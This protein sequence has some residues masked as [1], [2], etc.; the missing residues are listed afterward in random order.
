LRNALASNGRRLRPALALAGV[1]ALAGW[2]A[3]PG[4]APAPAAAPCTA[5]DR[6]L[7]AGTRADALAGAFRLTLV[8]TRGP[9]AD[10]S[11][12]GDLRLQP[13]GGRPVPLPASEGVRYALFGA[14]EVEIAGVGA[15]SRGAV[16]IDDAARPG[17]LAMEWTN[18]SAGTN[19]ITLRFGSDA[20]HGAQVPFDGA[21]LALQVRAVSADGFA[22]TWESGAGQPQAGGH[23]CAVRIAA[24]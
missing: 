8:A 20:N 15:V 19:E 3:C 17:V 13:F 23:F 9:R 2:G 11:A 10:D 22:G 1:F 16:D 7:E 4:R 6:E 5:A 18:A 21:Y 24:G 12:S 14:A